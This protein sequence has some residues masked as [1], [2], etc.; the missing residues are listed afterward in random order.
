MTR[1]GR[2]AKRSTLRP[3]LVQRTRHQ[4]WSNPYGARGR[5]Q[6]ASYLCLSACFSGAADLTR[7]L[8]VSVR[9]AGLEWRTLPPLVWR[10]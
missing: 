10:R 9:R 7:E 6:I 1:A 8:P 3:A 5:L 2:R 4:S